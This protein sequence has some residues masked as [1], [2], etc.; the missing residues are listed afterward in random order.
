V[1]FSP[2]S[3]PGKPNFFPVANQWLASTKPDG[4]ESS[5]H[6]T[7]LCPRL[8][9]NFLHTYASNSAQSG[10]VVAWK[11]LGWAQMQFRSVENAHLPEADTGK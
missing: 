7:L 10:M 2:H 3:Q 5:A 11:G 4:R 9:D 1:Q 6:D 8:G